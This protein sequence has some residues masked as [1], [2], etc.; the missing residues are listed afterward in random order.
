MGTRH[1]HTWLAGL[2]LAGAALPATASDAPIDIGWLLFGDLYYVPS[3]HTP[4]DDGAAGAVIRRGYLTLDV[5][6]GSDWFGRL[7]FEINQSG[8]FED[9][10]FD[11]QTKDLYLG[12]RLGDHK[13]IAGLA[14][15]PTFDLIESLWGLRYV[16]RTPLDLQGVAS[17]DTGVFASGPLG[18]SSTWSYRAM[19]APL[20]EFA[21]DGNDHR[22]IM[23]ALTWRPGPAWTVD[24]Y[25]DHEPVDGPHDRFSLQ[26]FAA[27]Q[28]D[29]LRWGLQYSNQ[30]RQQDPPLELASG[31]VVAR[32]DDRRSLYARVDR[33]FEP[34][35]KGD[36]IAY[37]PYDPSAP[38]TTLFAGVEYR[39]RDH[40]RLSP[41]FVF[42]RYDAD[43]QGD[44]PRPDLHLR[45]TLFLDFE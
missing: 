24:F 7:R 22:R 43:D 26:A 10:S 8:A 23:G 35:P 33:L 38:A 37:L 31:F 9:Y 3:H 6:G 27:Y 42:T 16:A 20:V 39:L 34:S 1:A 44:R 45:L 36:G 2:L 11:A 18:A 4:A 21:A 29:D 19:Y 5:G 13:L 28:T 41:N 15:T 30:D 12:R 14:A 40:L 17:R 25:A 32:L